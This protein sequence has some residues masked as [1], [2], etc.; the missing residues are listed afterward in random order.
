MSYTDIVIYQVWQIKIKRR[1]VEIHYNTAFLQRGQEGRTVVISHALL[2]FLLFNLEEVVKLNNN[3]WNKMTNRC[4]FF[5]IYIGLIVR[6]GLPVHEGTSSA[7]TQDT[8]WSRKNT[9]WLSL[10][11]SSQ[12]ALNVLILQVKCVCFHHRRSAFVFSLV[13]ILHSSSRNRSVGDIITHN[14]S[15]VMK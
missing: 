9:E 7:T 6:V 3:K 11:L 4:L 14:R 2:L 10:S 13:N 5:C 8:F 12:N 1:L 15:A